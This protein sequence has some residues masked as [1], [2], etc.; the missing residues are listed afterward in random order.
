MSHEN[1]LNPFD[2]EQ[3]QFTVLSNAQDQYSLW[4]EFAERPQGWETRFGPASR[5]SCIDF[6]ESHW[7]SIN[8]FSAAR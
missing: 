8:P 6:V 3:L 4:P 2:D 7:K 1:Y 5:S